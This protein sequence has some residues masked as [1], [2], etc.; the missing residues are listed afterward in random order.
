MTKNFPSPSAGRVLAYLLVIFLFT[1]G[2]VPAAGEA[3]PGILHWIA[4]LSAY[5]LIAAA[6]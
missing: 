1:L 5:G 2:S 4:H 3:F 6:I